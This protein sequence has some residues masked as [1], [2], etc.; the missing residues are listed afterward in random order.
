MKLREIKEYAL[1]KYGGDKSSVQYKCFVK[2]AEHVLNNQW[3][4]RRYPSENC[5][6]II[7]VDNDEPFIASF[8]AEKKEWYCFSETFKLSD[9]IAW[10]YIPEYE[11]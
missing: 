5:L 1:K 11:N 3:V 7:V 2:G 9:I 8:D 10:M 4:K 6:T